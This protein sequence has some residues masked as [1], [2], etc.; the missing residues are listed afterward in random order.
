MTRIELLIYCALVQAQYM[1]WSQ[2]RAKARKN[3]KRVTLRTHR[4]MGKDWR[5]KR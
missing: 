1:A 3:S 5:I 2:R 4:T